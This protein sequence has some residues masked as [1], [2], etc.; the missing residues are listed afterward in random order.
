MSKLNKIITNLPVSLTTEENEALSQTFSAVTAA[1]GGGG[2]QSIRYAGD[3]TTIVLNTTQNTFSLHQDYINAVQ[4]IP[5]KVADLTDSANYELAEHAASTYLTKASADNDYGAKADVTALKEASGGWNTAATQA[6]AL[7]AKSGDFLQADD[8]S[9]KQ[10]KLTF[11]TDANNKI[12]GINGTD[13]AQPNVS[14]FLTKT[15]ADVDYQPKGTY[16]TSSTI[17]GDSV[18]GLTTA[19][20]Q[21]VEGGG[22]GGG[23][24]IAVTHDDTL[25]GDGT[26]A[27][28]KLGVVW[29]AIS[30]GT[31]NSALSAGSAAKAALLGTSSLADITAAI[32]LK[33]DATDI[34]DMLTKTDAASTYQTQAGMTTYQTTAGMTAYQTTAGMSDYWKKTETSSDAQISAALEAKQ[35][36]LTFGYTDTGM[37]AISAINDMP[38]VIPDLPHITVI[39]G[40]YL[41]A[42]EGAGS[43]AGK[44]TVGVTN[45]GK[46]YL[47]AVPNKVNKPDVANKNFIYTTSGSTSGWVDGDNIYAKTADLAGYMTTAGVTI[48][49][50]SNLISVLPDDASNSAKLSAV[51]YV[52]NSADSN[53]KPQKLF[54]VRNDA[55]LIAHVTGGYCSGQGSLFFVMSGFNS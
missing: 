6:G 46:S 9:G 12:T 23:G 19:G 41:S 8:I 26:D 33:A 4:G 47:D 55:D 45:V 18:F 30:A 21:P 10:D 22:G 42:S 5:K 17:A 28:H 24:M 38:F 20:W 48:A 53:L 13:I 40:P 32:D 34:S 27:A 14:D 2:G 7:V 43:D 15:S 29:S 49:T 31:V 35:N 16:A 39:P 11:N 50:A 3:G 37:T 51:S 44:W 52:T 1:G 25:S 36:A 54:V